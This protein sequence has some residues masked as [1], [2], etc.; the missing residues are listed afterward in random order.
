MKNGLLTL[1]SVFVL[2]A[3]SFGSILLLPNEFVEEPDYYCISA[4]YPN[5]AIN[6][7][8]ISY[9]LPL[10]EHAELVLYNF[11][12]EKISSFYL[13][14]SSGVISIPIEKLDEGIYFIA[15]L[16]NGKI[17]CTKKLLVKKN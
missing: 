5:P 6:F 17:T 2:V 15:L 14:E 3:S 11:A 9:K 4:P 12:G 13:E 7:T 10:G 16:S 1:I 8:E